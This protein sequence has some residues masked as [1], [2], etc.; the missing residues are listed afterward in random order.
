MKKS[1]I[2]TLLIITLLIIIG[3]FF[4]FYIYN[5]IKGPKKKVKNQIKETFNK[6]VENE[7]FCLFVNDAFN[8]KSSLFSYKSLLFSLEDYL[9]S[10]GIEYKKIFYSGREGDPE[11][12]AM[13]LKNEVCN[14]MIVFTPACSV[15]Q[16][17][18]VKSYKEYGGKLIIFTSCIISPNG[19]GITDFK[20]FYQDVVGATPLMYSS[21]VKKVPNRISLIVD[22]SIAKE[23]GV[24]SITLPSEYVT[25]PLMMYPLSSFPIVYTTVSSAIGEEKDLATVVGTDG[26]VYIDMKFLQLYRDAKYDENLNEIF[27]KYNTVVQYAISKLI[28]D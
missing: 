7:K 17:N 9:S 22:S 6:L 28:L 20:A 27:N 19:K 13:Y 1:G 4:S 11:N 24:Y 15:D 16:Q 3:T 18:M 5:S 12:Y 23:T 25:D 8:V 26:V 2:S 14:K 10:N 21:F